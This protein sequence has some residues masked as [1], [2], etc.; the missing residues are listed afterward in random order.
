[1][2]FNLTISIHEQTHRIFGL[3]MRDYSEM[4]RTQMQPLFGTVSLFLRE[5]I[6]IEN[7][8]FVVS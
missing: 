1:M 2:K 3:A 5:V 7:S 6:N 8:A 4:H